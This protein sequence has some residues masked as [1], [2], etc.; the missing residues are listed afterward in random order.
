MRPTSFPQ[1]NRVLNAGNNPNTDQLPVAIS[2]DPATPGVCFI[3]SRFKMTHEER[4]LFE[5]TGDVWVSIMASTT[6]PTQ[7][8]VMLSVQDPFKDFGFEALDLT[9]AG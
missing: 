3:V 8:P 6:N 9:D 1:T 5:Q 7:P 4:E 2:L